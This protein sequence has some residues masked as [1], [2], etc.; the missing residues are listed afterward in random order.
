MNKTPVT[1]DQQRAIEALHVDFANRM[2]KHFTAFVGVVVDSDIAFVD[3][4]TYA[5]FIMSL[6]NPSVSYKFTV[7]PLDGPVV[8]DFSLPVAYQLIEH[9]L[10]AK[11]EGPITDAERSVLANVVRNVLRGLESCWTP[12][13]KVEVV[14]AVLETNPEAICIVDPSD[15][16]ILIAFQIHFQ[17]ANGLVTLAYPYKTLESVLSKFDA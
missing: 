16:V 5:E 8:L 3:Q 7:Q 12:I 13:E 6:P 17:H 14:D 11:A 15:I 2:E 1:K 9:E 4:T 10:S